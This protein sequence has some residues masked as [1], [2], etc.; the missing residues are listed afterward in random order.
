MYGIQCIQRA[1]G[2]AMVRFPYLILGLYCSPRCQQ[3]GD[4][5]SAAIPSC[6][7]EGSAAILAKADAETQQRHWHRHRKQV[8]AAHTCC[9]YVGIVSNLSSYD[10]TISIYSP[11]SFMYV[12]QSLGQTIYDCMLRCR[13]MIM[14]HTLILPYKYLYL[15]VLNAEWSSSWV[16]M[17][18]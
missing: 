2:C 11:S 12:G 1:M 13:A 5:L 8:R 10:K 6:P 17:V 7:V 14:I 15:K 4:H 9:G 3:Q 16:K 18:P